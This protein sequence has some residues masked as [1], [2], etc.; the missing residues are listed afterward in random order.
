MDKES[1]TAKLLD[2]A[3]GRETPE[4]WRGWWNEHETELETLLSGFLH[5]KNSGPTKAEPLF[6]HLFWNGLACLTAGLCY[7]QGLARRERF[8]LYHTEHLRL[9]AVFII[10]LDGGKIIEVAP[11]HIQHLG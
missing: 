5:T 11:P 8:S 7:L 3:E 10:L 1:L 9:A 4:T 2:L 6:S